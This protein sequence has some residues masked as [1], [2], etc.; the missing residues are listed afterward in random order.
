MDMKS[1]RHLTPTRMLAAAS[2]CLPMALTQAQA[3]SGSQKSPA[4]DE[5]D[6]RTLLR[7]GGEERAYTLLYMHGFVSGKRGQ[8]VLPTQDLAEA[9]DRIIDHCI[10]RPGDKLLPVF[11][12]VRA[13]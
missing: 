4:L 13:K 6:C 2:L 11:E 7:L 1:Q 3:A 10:E 5:L 9:T 12:K 8:T